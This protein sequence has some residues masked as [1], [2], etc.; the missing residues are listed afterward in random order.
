MIDKERLNEAKRNVK[1][2][3]D[4]GLMKVN[5]VDA[6]KFVGFFMANAESS[7]RTASVLQQISDENALK[8]TLKTGKDFESYL[9][10]IVSSYYAMFYA[11][12]A[13]LAK[14]GVR[15]AGQIVHKVTADALIHFFGSNEKLAKLLEQYEEAQAVG[16]E[17]IGR[18]ELMKRMQKKA[19]ELIV[20]YES[21]RK[22]RSKFQYD[23][24]IQAKRGYAQTSLERA[25]EFVFE[26]G[27]IVKT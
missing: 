24:G 11:A 7:L 19:D 12:T 14:Q 23:I 2:Y 3:V 15:A 9:W 8:E 21:E 13:L 18:D 16:L 1:Q 22:K 10:V 17:L 27:K 25:K 6:P 4:D 5:D 26:I 20:A